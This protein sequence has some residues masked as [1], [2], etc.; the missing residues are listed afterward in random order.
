M[1]LKLS[2]PVAVLGMVTFG[3][4]CS[5][6]AKLIY[7]VE[8]PTLYGGNARF[9]KPWF[10]VLAMFMGMS[11]CI[12]LDL[13]KRRL[14][15]TVVETRPL[16]S[17]GHTPIVPARPPPS[18]WIISIPTLL[19][20]FATACGTTGLL[21]T[22]VSVYQMLRGAMLVWTALLSVLFLGRRLDRLHFLGIALCVSGIALVGVANIAS[23]GAGVAR[24]N[25]V[26][27]IT[28]ILVGQVL[29]AAQVVVEEFLLK[30]LQISS[31]RIVAWEGL[32]GVAHCLVWVFPLIMLLPGRDHGR[33]ED[34]LDA[35]YMVFHSWKIAAVVGTDMIL[36]LGYNVCGM[37][38]TEHLS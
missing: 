31:M 19:D 37:E 21:Y 18:V 22:T 4:L 27:G 33:M 38:V 24:K 5:L 20:L 13:P 11:L 15:A 28:V 34:V 8:A 6:L 12:V 16:L 30:N 7:S 1:T 3:T 29:Q 17:N 2:A 10:Q 23:E 9:E 36:M 32:F 14:A 25:V 26:L 35:F